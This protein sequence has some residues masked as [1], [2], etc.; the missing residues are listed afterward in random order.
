[1]DTGYPA[2]WEPSGEDF[3]S[4]ALVEAALMQGV[5]NDGFGDWFD[6][7]LPKL[8]GGACANL[9]D[10]VEVSDPA[11]P[12]IVHLAGLNLS[13]A[14][15]W[16]RLSRAYAEGDPLRAR[17]LAAADAQIAAALPLVVGGDFMAE[18]WLASFALLAMTDA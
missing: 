17:M 10:P 8:A 12:R 1:E 6:R 15:C 4:P 3:L 5:L 9:F 2:G 18:H 7:F 16:R 14:W 13:R 11:D